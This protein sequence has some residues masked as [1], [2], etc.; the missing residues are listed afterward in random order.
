MKARRN[1]HDSDRMGR[2]SM[3]GYGKERELKR[4]ETGSG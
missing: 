3:D 1:I 2:S 4:K